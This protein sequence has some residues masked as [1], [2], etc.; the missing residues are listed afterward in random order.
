MYRKVIVSIAAVAVVLSA[1]S[2][3]GPHAPIVSADAGK[4]HL[5][6]FQEAFIPE[7]TDWVHAVQTERAFTG[8]NAWDGYM[9]LLVTDAGVQSLKSG[10]AVPER[11]SRKFAYFA[12]DKNKERESC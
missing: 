2:A 6:R 7:L 3:A 1:V 4:D 10:T 5:A 11:Y 8:A 12:V 9:S